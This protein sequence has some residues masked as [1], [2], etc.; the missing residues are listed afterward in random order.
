MKLFKYTTEKGIDIIKN[1]RILINPPNKFN[2][3]FEFFPT[4]AEEYEENEIKK[5]LEDIEVKKMVIHALKK[6]GLIPEDYQLDQ[7][8][9]KDNHKM[10]IKYIKDT[11]PLKCE[12]SCRKIIDIFSK[13]IGIFC[14]SL[15]DKNE[16][17]WSHYSDSHK[18]LLFEFNIPNIKNDDYEIYKVKY[19]SD[20]AK[21]NPRLNRN[22]DLYS[23][24]LINTI[25]TKSKSWKYE[26]EYR[27]FFPFNVCEKHNYNNKK[28]YFYNIKSNWI[29][30]VVLG[31]R[32]S[33]KLKNDISKLLKKEN[34]NHVILEK[35]ITSKDKFDFNYKGY[36][37][38]L[39]II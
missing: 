10:I 2:D 7:Y 33:L 21:I 4:I 5:D 22:K 17:L 13:K 36:D 39:F 35:S 37:G 25:I 8:F 12:I 26:K 32:S 20:R 38:S 1:L 27:I 30:R 14:T 24:E 28:I 23:K 15:E 29:S 34:L 11:W 18:G 6:E 31:C 16:L 9:F 3:P 19:S